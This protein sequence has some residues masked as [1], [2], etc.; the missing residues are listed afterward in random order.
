MLLLE[1]GGVGETQVWITTE[2]L[3]SEVS[4]TN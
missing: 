4:K 1:E 3:T 2:V